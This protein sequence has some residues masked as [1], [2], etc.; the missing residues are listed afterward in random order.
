MADTA[1][2]PEPRL[3][4]ALPEVLE[5]PSVVVD[6]DALDRNVAAMRD[7]MASRGVGLRPHTKTTKC[8]EIVRRQVDAGVV[9]LTVATLG[10]AEVLADAGFTQLFQAYPVWAGT[11]ARARRVRELHER[12]DLIVGVE[13]VAGV[14][15]LGAAV[16]GAD[17][18]LAVLIE[19]DPGM[20]RTGVEPAQVGHIARAALDAGLD[21]RGA[22]T[23]GGHVYSTCDAPGAADDEV[24]V[25]AQAV[26][27]LTAIGIV[28]PVLSAGSTATATMSARPPVTDERPGVYV[29]Q[30]RQQLAL[31]SAAADSIAMVVAAT[32]VASHGDGRFV[33]DA[34]SKALGTDRPPWLTGHGHVVGY[35]EA[36]LVALSEHHCVAITA[37]RRPAVGEVVA[38]VPNHCCTVVNLTD[39][40]VAVRRGEVVGHWQVAA[41]G[42]NT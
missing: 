12:C 36:T 16:A 27:V 17:R 19:L 9:G 32:V 38:V 13:S 7:A 23:F 5:T 37:G 2:T 10:E 11:S 24:R 39:V 1:P 42:R 3:Q 41:R 34:G 26:E 31:G 18:P 28:E 33:L 29:F 20:H 40:L 35:D 4:F 21:V 22:F 30:D 25:L 6:V 8:I 15:A 14:E